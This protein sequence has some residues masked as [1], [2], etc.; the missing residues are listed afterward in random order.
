VIHGAPST[1]QWDDGPAD[2]L[3]RLIDFDILYLD[4]ELAVEQL[5][6]TGIYD[7]IS[8]GFYLDD[9]QVHWHRMP[10]LAPGLRALDIFTTVD[11]NGLIRVFHIRFAKAWRDG[12]A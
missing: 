3:D 4:V 10:P 6:H 12:K 5:I 9:A 2:F 1:I 8:L 7:E 11:A